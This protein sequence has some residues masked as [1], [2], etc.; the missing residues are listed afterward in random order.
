[1]EPLPLQR[2]ADVQPAAESLRGRVILIA[3]ALGGLGH[4]T[5]LA[6]ASAGATL[7]LCARKVKPLEALYDEIEAMGGAQPALYPIDFEGATP[8]DYLDLAEAVRYQCGRLDGLV[9]AAVHFSGLRSIEQ[10]SPTEWLRN[11]QVNV[12]APYLLSQACLPLLR[13]APDAALVFAL[14]DGQR[15]NK[16]FWSGYGVAKAGVA[17]LAAILHQET[18]SSAV[19]VHAVLPPP[20]RTA[21]RRMAYFGENSMER[22]TPERAGTAVAFLL[23]DGGHP[24][25]GKTLD[26]RDFSDAE[27]PLSAASS[28]T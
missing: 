8:Q 19:R 4:A 28:A 20:M 9:Y 23:G 7:V 14:D 13:E 27:H 22:E 11:Q 15:T 24:L 10:T 18:D 26:L 21:M 3:G 6:C 5:A 2:V 12:N 17:S 1:M 16:A 25:R